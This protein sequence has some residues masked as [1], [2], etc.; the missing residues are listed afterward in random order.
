MFICEKKTHW[1]DY[2]KTSNWNNKLRK[3]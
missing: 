3:K 1:W 2:W